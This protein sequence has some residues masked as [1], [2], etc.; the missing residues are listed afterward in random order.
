MDLRQELLYPSDHVRRHGAAWRRDTHAYDEIPSL[1]DR[2]VAN[3]THVDD[4]DRRVCRDAARVADLM[5][6]SHDLVVQCH[7]DTPLSSL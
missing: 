7:A 5:Q 3:Q 6:R 2:P 1:V 4:A